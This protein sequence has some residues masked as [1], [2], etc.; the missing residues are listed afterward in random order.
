MSSTIAKKAVKISKQLQPKIVPLEDDYPQILIEKNKELYDWT[1]SHTTTVDSQASHITCEE[2]AWICAP[3]FLPSQKN[4]FFFKWSDQLV[5]EKMFKSKHLGGLLS[6]SSNWSFFWHHWTSGEENFKD[7]I[8]WNHLWSGKA[9][10]IWK[11]D[12]FLFDVSFRTEE[13]IVLLY[14]KFWSK[15]RNPWITRQCAL[16]HT[17]ESSD[18]AYYFSFKKAWKPKTQRCRLPER[19]FAIK[20]GASSKHSRPRD[21]KTWDKLEGCFLMVGE[22]LG[23]I[24]LGKL[25]I[26]TKPEW[27][28]DLGRNSRYFFHLA[29]WPRLLQIFCTKIFGATK[30]EVLRSEFQVCKCVTPISATATLIYTWFTPDQK[31]MSYRNKKNIHTDQDEFIK[32]FQDRSFNSWFKGI[33]KWIYSM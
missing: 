27:S 22:I 11:D 14:S 17:K 23:W 4:V 5:W 2:C 30:P 33:H 8:D 28:G 24:F 9:F 26:I 6:P 29:E 15:K 31:S 10:E 21:K 32:T 20:N 7:S 19:F 3:A 12:V 16:S 25:L 13:G 18:L 1:I